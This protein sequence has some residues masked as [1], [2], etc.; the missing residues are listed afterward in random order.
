MDAASGMLGE[1]P[2]GDAATLAVEFDSV[3]D[4]PP[5]LAVF[6]LLMSR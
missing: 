5:S 2:V 4:R 3:D 1:E 6:D